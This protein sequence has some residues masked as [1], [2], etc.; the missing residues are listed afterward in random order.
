MLNIPLPPLPRFESEAMVYG[1][2]A[3]AIVLG[4]ALLLWGRHLH[5]AV[6]MLAGA[7]AGFLL[8]E[9]LGRLIGAEIDLARA[10]AMFTAAVLALA[11]ARVI[12]PAIAGAICIGVATIVLKDFHGLLTWPNAATWP[13]WLDAVRVAAMP[14]VFLWQHHAKEMWIVL[15]G[16]GAVVFVLGVILGRGMAVFMTALIGAVAIGSGVALA[17]LHRKPEIWPAAWQDLLIPA[18]VVGG[19]VLLGIV[20]QTRGL[21]AARARRAEAESEKQKSETPVARSAET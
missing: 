14:D 3:G 20:G 7:G 5:R 17:V 16:T 10:V 18:A 13:E 2:A 1:V 11:L 12:W 8:A 6:L 4:V 9:P 15:G 19:V 21:L